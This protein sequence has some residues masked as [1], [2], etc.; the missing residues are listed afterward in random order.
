MVWQKQKLKKSNAS[1]APR[2]SIHSHLD[3]EHEIHQRSSHLRVGQ[4]YF[5]FVWQMCEYSH[6]ARSFTNR[7]NSLMEVIATQTE[8]VILSRQHNQPMQWNWHSSP[9]QASLIA[10]K[11]GISFLLETDA[12]KN[13]NAPRIKET[14]FVYTSII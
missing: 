5:N 12:L 4:G 1:T 7:K 9:N 6:T 14:F 3:G 8:N 2:R 13:R 11:L 10:C